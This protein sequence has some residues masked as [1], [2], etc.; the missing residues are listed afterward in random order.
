MELHTSRLLL[1]DFTLVDIEAVH[2]Y[3]SDPRYLAHTPWRTR[4]RADVDDFVRLM[5]S[6]SQAR[7]RIR[8]QLAIVHDALLIGSCGIRQAAQDA[9]EAEFGCELAPAAWGHGYAAEA[10]HAILAFGFAELRLR[11]ICANTTTT[12]RPAIALAR[13]LG[14]REEV[15]TRQA[16]R[17]ADTVALGIST[18]SWNEPSGPA[19]DSQCS[20]RVRTP[21]SP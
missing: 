10:S 18:R 2:A 20:S 9:T 8:Y 14:M 7:P 4:S 21:R 17:N 5:I 19:F 1:R 13:R 16:D 3:Q 15:D 6:W 11:R 12:N